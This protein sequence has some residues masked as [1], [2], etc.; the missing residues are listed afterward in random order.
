MGEKGSTNIFKLNRIRKIEKAGAPFFDDPSFD[1]EDY[2]KYTLGVFHKN[3]AEPILVHLKF[4]KHLVQ[5]ILENK[6]HP[7]MEILRQTDEELEITL[8]VY[9]TIELKNLLLS[10]GANVTVLA[11]ETLRQELVLATQE[12][13]NNYI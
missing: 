3:D 1:K 6:I 5:L 12:I 9:N 10:Y 8:K 2:F 4:K 11:P 7:T 13:L